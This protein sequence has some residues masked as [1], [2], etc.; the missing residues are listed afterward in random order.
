MVVTQ[1]RRDDRFE[2]GRVP[3]QST[4]AEESVLGAILLSE[5]AANEVMDKLV[6]EDFY[7]PANQ[8]IFRAM[9]LLYNANQAIDAITVSEEL[10]RTGELDRIGGISGITRLLDI[11]P[12]ASNVDYY[13][14]IVDEHSLRRSLMRAGSSITDLA[15]RL[16]EEVHTV[17][18][19]AEQTVL[20]VAARRVKDSMLPIGPVFF[21]TLEEL[22]A[23][24]A[25]GSEI[26]GLSTGFK[27]LDRKLTGLHPNNLIIIAA[28][29]GMGKSALTMNI[30][31]NA[32]LAGKTVAI[33]SL[34][35]GK[36]EIATRMLCS[37]ARIDSMKV[38]TGQLGESA[39]PRLT[40]AAGKLYNAP[41]FV[42]DSQW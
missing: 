17:I 26:T 28:R 33:F 40:D 36:E 42:D 31:T 1:E 39:W 3:P 9:R 12:S 10:R 30:A 18:D 7:R 25:R 19:R 41:V 37:V 21:T 23:A 4:E 24:E 5:D 32:A 22:E 14:G 15:M 35:M 8:A 11:V 29:P 27:D 38:R 16:D 34:E 20:A 2:G 13:A 6:P